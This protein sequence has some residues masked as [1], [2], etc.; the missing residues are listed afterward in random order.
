[1]FSNNIAKS[2]LVKSSTT[3]SITGQVAACRM[4]S[5]T[6]RSI[7]RLNPRGDNDELSAPFTRGTGRDVAPKRSG[8]PE[9]GVQ[10]EEGP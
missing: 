7:R 2:L 9:E 6:N 4:I 3:S 8:Y 10:M 1:M 5:S